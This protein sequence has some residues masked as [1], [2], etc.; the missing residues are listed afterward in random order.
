MREKLKKNKIL[1]Y[2]LILIC[3]MAF[4]ALALYDFSEILIRNEQKRGIEDIK[5]RA[6]KN[7]QIIENEIQQ[8]FVVLEKDALD[9]REEGITEESC[10]EF[11]SSM[12]ELPGMDFT[13][14]GIADADGHAQMSTGERI[15]VQDQ[16]FFREAMSGNPYITD[17]NEN[18]EFLAIVAVPVTGA[19][20]SVTGVLFGEL[21][22][23]NMMLLESLQE[24]EDAEGDSGIKAI[25]LTDTDGTY[26]LKHG[27]EKR[28]KSIEDTLRSLKFDEENTDITDKNQVLQ[29]MANREK[30]MF[31]VHNI[32]RNEIVMLTPVEN[33]SWY[34]YEAVDREVIE[35]EV[36]YYQ[37]DMIFLTVK[38][39]A[40]FIV[41][42]G[43]Y[44][45]YNV[46]ERKK[47]QTLYRE[48]SMNEEIYRIVAERSNL[49]IFTFDGIEKKI[50]FMNDKYKE[51]GLPDQ[52]MEL[53]W[54]L[55]K[56]E[57]N[58][59]S[60][61]HRV[62]QVAESVYDY[63][64]EIERELFVKIEGK[65]R[66]LTVRLVN[67]FDK[68]KLVSPHSIGM[69]EDITQKKE[70]LMMMKREQDFRNS[71]LSDCMGY[72]E[73]NIT[74][75]RVI[76]NSFDS[77][78]SDQMRGTF[79][80][81]IAYY[82]SKKVM[83]EYK[84]DIL[85][86]MSRQAIQEYFDT[87]IDDT[88]LEYQAMEADGNVYWIA[89]NIRVKQSENQKELIA[90]LIYRNIDKRKKEQMKLEKE[91]TFDTLTGAYKRQPAKE[92]IQK[93]MQETLTKGCCHA[94]LLLDMDN[95]KTLND[96]L[97][98]MCGDQALINFVK[99]AKENCRHQDIVCRLGGDEF[100]IFLE[101]TVEDAV[102]KKIQSL[103]EKFRVTY[104]KDGKSVTVSASIG[105]VL[106]RDNTR[107]FEELYA[108]ADKALYRVKTTEK[109][110][111]CF[112]D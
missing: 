19:D 20:D 98:H 29:G 100:I 17:R 2:I 89:C 13:R 14:F 15:P 79:T 6:Q 67:L 90:Y 1:S 68:Q 107:N 103:Q 96:T 84:E 57:K 77:G 16:N 81:L 109:G 95:F 40:L 92:K 76:E 22:I 61:M 69:L 88:V 65:N 45:Y 44:V 56:M 49:C 105:V 66:F 47:I 37:K 86:R 104:E 85:L 46:K 25:C 91:A 36:K 32:S 28:E 75:D 106:I 33:S 11:L 38:I 58:N 78:T 108:L 18:E 23:N 30:L 26:L 31:S 48:L 70:N 63:I 94:F 64:P 12:E 93:K 112:A 99:I 62:A 53:S 80:Q 5:S 43:I 50:Y 83:P 27:G 110:T 39:L 52:C 72:L 101:S 10:T 102:E 41:L 34:L 54:L 74:E 7:C 87:G 59:L 73:V 21:P 71:L 24:Q 82:V 42:I 97:G 51:F 9:L 111:Y 8:Y 55:K 35:R 3:V 60:A 4:L